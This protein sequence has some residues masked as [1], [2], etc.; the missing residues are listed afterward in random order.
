M[1]KMYGDAEVTVST[2]KLAVDPVTPGRAFTGEF[3]TLYVNCVLLGTDEI[4]N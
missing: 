1:L 3:C 2:T 4:T